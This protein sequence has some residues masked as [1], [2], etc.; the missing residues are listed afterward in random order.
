MDSFG[1][2]VR[3]HRM[4]EKL[5]LRK[6]AAFLDI[7]QAIL[8][9]IERGKRNATRDQVLGLAQ[10]YKIDADQLLVAWLSD[11]IVAEL[12]VESSSMKALQV[13]EEKIAYKT[14]KKTSKAY[15][16]KKII[17]V[18]KDFPVIEKAWVFGSFAREDDTPDSDIDILI[19]VPF[20]KEFT[21]FDIA[22]IQERLRHM[23]NRSVDVVMLRALKS[24][25]KQRIQNDLKL[26]YEAR[27]TGKQGT[28]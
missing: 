7:D 21:L 24:Q 1:D 28:D 4:E 6:I 20:D 14:F 15:T 10:F 3:R 16:I 13:A 9:K 18:L 12:A 17:G 25:V 8:S 19:D 22:E 26:I 23:I 11:K 5:P 2:I 27:Q